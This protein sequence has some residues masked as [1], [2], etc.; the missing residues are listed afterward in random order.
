MHVIAQQTRRDNAFHLM[1]VICGRYPPRAARRHLRR[2]L[3]RFSRKESM[4]GW[5]FAEEDGRYICARWQKGG[6]TTEGKTNRRCILRA[7]SFVP[8]CS[9]YAVSARCKWVLQRVISFISS[10]LRRC[11]GI[12]L[13]RLPRSFHWDAL[14][15]GGWRCG[16]ARQQRWHG[17]SPVHTRADSSPA[18][19]API[20]ACRRLTFAAR[21]CA[22][23]ARLCRHSPFLFLPG[24]MG[25]W[26]GII[27]LP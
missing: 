18:A 3:V 14:Y 2:I 5:C 6:T 25:R 24:R 23:T 13:A 21:A 27:H 17:I 1:L 12:I 15:F 7:P 4:A 11:L 26:Y 16:S 22:L 10:S 9:A 20:F 8:R 19:R